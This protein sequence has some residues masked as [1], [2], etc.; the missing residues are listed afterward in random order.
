MRFSLA[1][2]MCD[3]AQYVPLAQAAEEVGFHAYTLPDSIAY[4]EVSDSKYPYTPDGDRRF[5]EDKPFIEPFSLIPALAMATERLRFHT[6]VVKLA[7][8]HPL[9]VAKQ[10]ASVA[11][12]TNDRFGF[13]VGV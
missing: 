13:G 2:T 12:M 6:F 8:R 4:P 3:P 5:L 1:E 11:V 7:I 9:L 10:A